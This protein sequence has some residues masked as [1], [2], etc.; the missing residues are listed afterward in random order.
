MTPSV[1]D[2]LCTDWVQ[3]SLDDAFRLA[4]EK[5]NQMEFLQTYYNS[6][7][8]TKRSNLAY[9]S[10]L[11][12]MNGV[13]LVAFPWKD[14]K[15]WVD[16][17]KMLAKENEEMAHMAQWSIGNDF[18]GTSMSPNMWD[19]V[20][21]TDV[22]L[23]DLDRG[24]A[25]DGML[26]YHNSEGQNSIQ[27]HLKNL[28]GATLNITHLMNADRFHRNRR[29]TWVAFRMIS[30]NLAEDLNFESISAKR[31]ERAG[32]K[33]LFEAVGKTVQ[34]E[35]K[36]MGKGLVDGHVSLPGGD[37]PLIYDVLKHGNL[38]RVNRKD[39]A[40]TADKAPE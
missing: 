37:M 30:R 25:T 16:E 19:H 10:F 3:D 31:V 14:H 32:I 11:D 18:G 7:D 39:L 8:A 34:P 29:D 1:G 36:K 28:A 9:K 20:F 2:T 12:L 4:A 6:L 13:F 33:E 26:E 21:N 38:L 40:E 5:V 23:E 27:T 22:A 24:R 15:S 17:I 35:I